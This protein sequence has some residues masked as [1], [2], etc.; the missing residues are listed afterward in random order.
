MSRH[1]T[2]EIITGDYSQCN[3]SV[4]STREQKEKINEMARR[5]GRTRSGM[6]KLL[7]EFALSNYA[8][9]PQGRAEG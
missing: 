3:C 1:A 5:E 8:P 9:A 2:K 7:I 4:S 6:S